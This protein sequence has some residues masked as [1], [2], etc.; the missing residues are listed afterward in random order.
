MTV[1]VFLDNLDGMMFNHRRQ[2]QDRAA[3][4]KII[5]MTAG[6]ALWVSEYTAPLF[7]QLDAPNLQVDAGFLDK[8]GPGEFCLVEDADIQPFSYFI[9]KIILFKW[10]RAYPSDKKFPLDVHSGKW[11]CVSQED[12]AGSSH[13]KITMEVYER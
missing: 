9:E 7:A 6:S 5:N 11:H 4:Q 13:E 3:V 2:S 10:N 1:I 8:A 12:F